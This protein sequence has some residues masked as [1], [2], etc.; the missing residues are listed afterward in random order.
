MQK[1]KR[2]EYKRR[3]ICQRKPV[4]G[5]EQKEGVKENM[6]KVQYIQV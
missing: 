6:I 4:G 5:G 3:T 2:H 1:Q